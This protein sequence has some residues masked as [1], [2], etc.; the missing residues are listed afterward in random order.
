MSSTSRHDYTR[1][2][3]VETGSRRPSTS[4]MSSPTPGTGA[5]CG[6]RGGWRYCAG[7]YSRAALAHVDQP[8]QVSRMSNDLVVRG[9]TIITAA[10]RFVADGGIRAGRIV[11][12]GEAL[13]P[14]GPKN[15]P[16]R[17]PG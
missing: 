5:S 14:P 3:W 7:A 15:D 10:D 6:G 13:P 1:E 2:S 8:G 16:P 9:G 4:L 17:V 11:E 12:I